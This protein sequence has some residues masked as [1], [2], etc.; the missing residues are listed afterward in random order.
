MYVDVRAFDKMI[1]GWPSLKGDGY[2]AGA[3]RSS[4]R[5]SPGVIEVG[6]HSAYEIVPA[7]EFTQVVEAGE[8]MKVDQ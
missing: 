2:Q 6:N 7:V 5:N 8:K 1:R 3:E 4:G